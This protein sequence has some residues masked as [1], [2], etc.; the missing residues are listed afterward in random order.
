MSVRTSI[1]S[2]LVLAASSACGLAEEYRVEANREAPP[3]TGVAKEVV[4]QLATSGV[5]VTGD[6]PLCD[7]W[8]CKQ[9]P[10]KGA[11]P[12]GGEVNYP[13][14][15]GQLIGLVRYRAKGGDF[16][17]QEV[18]RGLY[19]LRY[20]QQPV[21]GNH[22]GTSPT[23]DFLLLSKADK[24][25]SAKPLDDK[26]LVKLSTEVSG[27]QHPALLCLVPLSGKVNRPPSLQHDEQ[28]ERWMIRLRGTV[29][30]DGKSTPQ[31]LELVVVGHAAE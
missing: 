5:T 6:K 26:A 24:D 8:L 28:A 12:A 3:N 2:L 27:S 9:W 22:V 4:D 11:A 21:D 7:I 13:F 16:R 14:T 1:A 30:R 19:T 23:R 31:D 10:V 20:A 18:A 29:V 25:T 15:P 17:D